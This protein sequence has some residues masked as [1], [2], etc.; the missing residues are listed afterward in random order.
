MWYESGFKFTMENSEISALS[1][2]LRRG[3]LH[4]LFIKPEFLLNRNYGQ[5]H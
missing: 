2:H 3:K 5:I 4:S 1:L